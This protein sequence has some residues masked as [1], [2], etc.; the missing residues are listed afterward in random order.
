MNRTLPAHE[1]CHHKTFRLTCEQYE[2]L[3]AESE[4]EC[5][6]CAKPAVSTSLG[7]LVIDHDY[8]HGKWAVRGL[9]CGSCNSL[10]V[11]G[12]EAPYWAQPYLTDPWFLRE[13]ARLNLSPHLPPEPSRDACL[14]DFDNHIW[15]FEDN[16]WRWAW[17]KSLRLTWAELFQRFGPMGLTQV[18]RDELVGSQAYKAYLQMR[19]WRQEREAEE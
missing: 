19:A 15:F 10:F 6:A 5:M 18:D 4:N 13:V 9:I 1:T 3:I 7:K 8:D 17:K 11:R 12:V 2:A 14:R 16:A